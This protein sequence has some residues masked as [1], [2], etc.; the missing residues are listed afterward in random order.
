MVPSCWMLHLSAPLYLP[1]CKLSLCP[2]HCV[3][4]Q[5]LPPLPSW[6]L[7][8]PSSQMPSRLWVTLPR[9][10]PLWI[11]PRNH[12]PHTYVRTTHFLVYQS[13]CLKGPKDVSEL[14][15]GVWRGRMHGPPAL[16]SKPSCINLL[17]ELP[18]T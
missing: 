16:P 11:V 17:W 2:F 3:G 12:Q 10:W 7:Q 18:Q 8:G 1:L 15:S 9:G 14:E 4:S 5:A 6:L 13:S